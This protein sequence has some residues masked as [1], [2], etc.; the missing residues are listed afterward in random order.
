MIKL[1]LLNGQRR[2]VSKPWLQEK[3]ILGGPFLK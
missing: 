1:M 2:G 3:H